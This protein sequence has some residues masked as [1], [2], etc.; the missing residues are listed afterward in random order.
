MTNPTAKLKPEVDTLIQRGY[1]RVLRA[2]VAQISGDVA[3]GDIVDVLDSRGDFIG[4]GAA[5]PHARVFV[6]MFTYRADELIDDAFFYNRLCQARRLRERYAKDASYRAVFAESDGLPGLIVDR[7]ED[8]LIC[9]IT[10]AGIEVRR[11]RIFSMLQDIYK[12]HGI[13]EKSRGMGRKS[14]RLERRVETV[15]GECPPLIPFQLHGLTFLNDVHEGQKTGFFL[16]QRENREA[17][18][19]YISAGSSVLDGFSYTGG[20]ALVAAKAGAQVTA[21][22]ISDRALDVAQKAA[23]ENGLQDR[24]VFQRANAFDTMRE[25]EENGAQFDMVILDPPAFAKHKGVLPKAIRAYRTINRRAMKLLPEG[26]ILVSCS[27]TQLVDEPAFLEMLRNAAH[28]AGRRL[29]FLEIRGQPFDHP[30]LATLPE[31]RYL[32]CVIG[33]VVS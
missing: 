22:D 2:N 25:F 19:R 23:A 17:I 6:R 33:Q 13:F 3:A 7:F 31:T 26:G 5:N 24:C 15:F 32:K 11:D 28:D 29:R 4:R 1:P 20:F 21:F 14:E 16:D 10:A 27:C 12:P 9:Q 8:Y 18:R 30:V